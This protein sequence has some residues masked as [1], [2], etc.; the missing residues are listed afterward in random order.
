MSDTSKFRTN[1]AVL[2]AIWAL[3]A[4]SMLWLLWHYPLRT[5]IATF[6]ILAGLDV[7]ARL[8]R[9]MDSEMSEAS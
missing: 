8:A 4:T 7:S 1:L 2:L 6:I 5:A 9:S 3:S